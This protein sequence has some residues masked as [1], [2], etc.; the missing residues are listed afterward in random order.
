TVKTDISTEEMDF[1][2]TG[3]DLNY[4]YDESAAVAV[5]E[6]EDIIKITA[7]GTY[8]VTGSHTQINVNAPD[9]A[10]IK[11]V[12]KDAEIVNSTGPAIYIEAA[13]KVFITALEGTESS[14]SDGAE[15]SAEY[16][17]SNVDAAIFSRADLTLNG[18]GTLN[19]NGKL[20]CGIASKDDLVICGLNLNVTSAG[21][22]IE[23]KDCVKSTDASVS[24]SAGGDGIKATNTEDAG[25][26]YVYIE[27]G[28]F[29]ITA[30]NDGIEAET[31]LKITGGKFTVKTGGGSENGS[32]H[33]ESFGGRGFMKNTPT[34]STEDTESAKALK[35]S[36]LI[37]VDGGEFEIDS[38]DDAVHSN[39]DAEIN[40]G[41]FSILSGD[42]GIHADD[43]LL[44]NGGEI[45]VKKSYEGLEG[46]AIT[47][48][49]GK[50]DVTASD[51][52]INAA[53][54]NDS[55]SLG[56][57]PGEN[58]F[59]SS[60]AAQINIT[61]GYI[62]VNAAGDGVDSNGSIS[63]SGGVLLV[64]GPTNSGNGAFDYDS[65]AVITGGTAI[66]CGSSGMAQGFSQS[67]TQASFMYTLDSTAA[68]GES[69]AVT[70]SSGKVIASFMPSK[71]YSNIVV[72]SPE[73]TVGDSCTVTLGGTVSEAD[74]NGYTCSGKVS[75]GK[76]SFSVEI[77]SVATSNG[78]G[79][80]GGQP[81][82]GMGGGKPGGMMR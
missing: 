7:E 72:S 48:S 55:S 27:S 32:V 52:G 38:A 30:A 25:R 18:K 47:V 1:E 78:S 6:G 31:A 49:G 41:S 40:G 17:D 26:G 42:D 66:L 74:Q 79:G 24:I 22:A 45:T 2:F 10:K 23:G 54:G 16:S 60:S 50:I 20:K 64:S 3:N 35:C 4:G 13:D 12:L 44:I 43:A 67:S 70:D 81:D 34:E 29:E 56:G 37:T 82:R 75:G 21:R 14:V 19:V 58:S 36:S 63:M 51:D 39:S 68:A 9:T 5:D 46:T 62:L 53:G 80:M 15:Y 57:R 61:G 59:N 8:A 11:I 73:L 33:T 77:T 65:S 76:S 28:S 71:E 69:L